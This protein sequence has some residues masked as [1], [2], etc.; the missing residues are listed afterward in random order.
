MGRLKSVSVFHEAESCKTKF[1]RECPKHCCDD[2][3]EEYKVEDLSK[4][5][6]NYDF[7]PDLQ[8]ISAIHYAVILDEL[9]LKDTYKPRYLNFKPPL[10]EQDI[11][12]LVQSF[13]L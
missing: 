9:Y 4:V 6:H 8:L 2:Q 3:Q 11:P 10:I 1:G 5:N 7:S 13:L 12:V